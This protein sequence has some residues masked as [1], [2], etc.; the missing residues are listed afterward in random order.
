MVYLFNKYLIK[1]CSFVCLVLDT[2]NKI[3]EKWHGTYSQGIF[4]EMEGESAKVS[5]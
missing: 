4:S 3:S 1:V 2:E 5:W